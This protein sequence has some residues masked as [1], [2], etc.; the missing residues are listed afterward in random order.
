MK[1]LIL[2]ISICLVVYGCNKRQR[3][4]NY[5]EGEWKPV[6]FWYQNADGF[7]FYDSIP[8]GFIT[9]NNGL[10]TGLMLSHYHTFQG[11][12][13]D[14]LGLQGSVELDI[15]QSQLNWITAN[16]TITSRLFSLTS[17]DLVFER[18]DATTKNRF[19]YILKKN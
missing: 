7:T 19:R 11:F 5:L 17:N 10:T 15:N 6:M 16:D 2:W 4:L 18:Y 1:H 9:V 3:L 14:S 8:S 13:T 12:L